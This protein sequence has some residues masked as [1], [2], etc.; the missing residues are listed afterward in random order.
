[1]KVYTYAS[2]WK[3]QLTSYGGKS[4]EYDALGNPTKYLDKELSWSYGRQLTGIC[5]YAREENG[6]VITDEEGNLVFSDTPS[7]TYTYTNDGNRLTKTVD[8]VTTRYTLNRSQILREKT[9]DETLNYYY[10]GEGKLT[11]IGYDNGTSADAEVLYTIA[12]NAQG[13]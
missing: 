5:D 1:M 8:G 6:A 3:N 13:I 10:D 9:G 2:G 11:S 7:I 4:I 12:R